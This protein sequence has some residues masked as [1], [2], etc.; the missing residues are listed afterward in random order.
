MTRNL[1]AEFGAFDVIIGDRSLGLIVEEFT[2]PSIERLTQKS[3]PG[4]AIGA[5]KTNHGL[6]DDLKA[7]LKARGYAKELEEFGSALALDGTGLILRTAYTDK[8]SSES[9]V[10]EITMR[11]RINKRMPFGNFR[12]GD[13]TEGEFELDLVFYE[14]RRGGKTIALVDII[15][16]RFELNGV[17]QA[18]A[19][20]ALFA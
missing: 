16:A 17:D 2:P 13:Q 4:G 3:R 20:T 6:V 18:P 10:I 15:N 12:Q 9:L 5:I 1:A 11:G 7:T 19:H 14:E 8:K